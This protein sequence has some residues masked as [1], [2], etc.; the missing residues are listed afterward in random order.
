MILRQAEV[1]DSKTIAMAKDM[2]LLELQVCVS[3]SGRMPS[4]SPR[5][6]IMLVPGAYSRTGPSC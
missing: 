3:P 5:S 2:L 6:C 4:S 1:R